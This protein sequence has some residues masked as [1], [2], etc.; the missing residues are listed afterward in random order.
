MLESSW[1][2]VEGEGNENQRP[3][4]KSPLGVNEQRLGQYEKLETRNLRLLI[5]TRRVR[6]PA[7]TYHMAG[8]EPRHYL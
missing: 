7:T 5:T 6:S 4:T 3:K 1:S 8:T 2:R